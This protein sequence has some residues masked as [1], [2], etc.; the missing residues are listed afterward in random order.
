MSRRPDLVGELEREVRL[1]LGP[2]AAPALLEAFDW[3]REGQ[4]ITSARQTQLWNDLW[5]TLSNEH[6]E[7][8]ARDLRR[9]IVDTQALAYLYVRR[10]YPASVP[11]LKLLPAERKALA[12]ARAAF[13]RWSGLE[14]LSRPARFRLVR[15]S[16]PILTTE[17]AT[18]GSRRAAMTFAWSPGV[19]RVVLVYEDFVS[20]CRRDD[21]LWL[22][23]GVLVHEELHS[24]HQL[25]AGCPLLYDEADRITPLVEELCAYVGS[26]VAE[27]LLHDGRVPTRDELQEWNGLTHEGESLNALLSLWPDLAGG[28]EIVAAAAKLAVAVLRAGGEQNV[29]D[30]LAARSPR[31]MNAAWWRGQLGGA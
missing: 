24:A 2:Q 7:L 29:L 28:D 19:R 12:I 27:L 20:E 11:P 1:R 18:W 21:R 16:C 10:H 6:P 8:F 4:R 14:A 22:L 9:A 13:R 25:Q 3:P 23:V 17:R 5:I 31:Q 30:L 26:N 15:A